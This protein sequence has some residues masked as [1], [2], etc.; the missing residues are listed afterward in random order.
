MANDINK[1]S[2]YVLQ[3]QSKYV[4]N[5]STEITNLPASNYECTFAVLPFIAQGHNFG[6]RDSKVL[7]GNYDSLRLSVNRSSPIYF[8]NPVNTAAGEKTITVHI[9]FV[10]RNI[11]ECFERFD[12]DFEDLK[13]IS[14]GLIQ[15]RYHKI[16]VYFNQDKQALHVLT[17]RKLTYQTVLKIYSVLP[18]LYN[19]ELKDDA[20]LSKECVAKYATGDAELVND[21]IYKWLVKS[22]VATLLV[23]KQLLEVFGKRA[24][25]ARRSIQNNIDSCTGVINDYTERLRTEALK[26]TRFYAELRGIEERG[27]SAVTEIIQY[28]AKKPGFQF[29]QYIPR[30]DVITFTV[31]APA[32]Y[33]DEDVAKRLFDNPRSSVN[34]YAGQNHLA[35]YI[36]EV[37]KNVFID[38]TLKLYFKACINWDLTNGTVALGMNEFMERTPGIQNPHLYEYGCWGTSKSAIQKA[39]IAQDYIIALEQTFGS[40]GNINWVDSAVVDKLFTGACYSLKA[41]YID[42]PCIVDA[43]DKLW[44]IRDLATARYQNAQ[45]A[46]RALEAPEVTEAPAA[47]E[48]PAAVEEDNDGLF[49]EDDFFADDDDDDNTEAPVIE[50]LFTAD[51]ITIN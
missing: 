29:I 11:T 43:D 16:R 44:T 8:P 30:N 24:E 47:P 41:T 4:N 12:S 50:D 15:E 51:N 27:D 5:N 32:V 1:F 6:H 14:I 7:N 34:S 42:R 45:A 46:L 2:T 49:D 28:F 38:H 26:Q 19:I 20:L 3:L 23:N 13:P 31:S 25:K 21:Y 37:F 36:I 35:P 39:L 22:D 40:V 48:A 18:R 17:N 10:T 33:Y 9:H